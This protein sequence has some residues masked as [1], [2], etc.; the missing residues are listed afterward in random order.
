MPVWATQPSSRPWPKLVPEPPMARETPHSTGSSCPERLE[1]LAGNDW[2]NVSQNAACCKPHV[3]RAATVSGE[4]VSGETWALAGETTART[5]SDAAVKNTFMLVPS[6]RACAGITYARV[7]WRDAKGGPATCDC[8][9][10]WH[11]DLR[12]RD[13]SKLYSCRALLGEGQEDRRLLALDGESYKNGYGKFGRGG[14]RGGWMFASRAAWE[15]TYGPIPPNLCA[16]HHCDN[17]P[18]VRPDHLFLGTKAQNSA[19]M[20]AKGRST[21]GDRNPTRLYPEC[22]VR[23]ERQWLAKLSS[24]VVR[25]IRERYEAGGITQVALAAEYGVSFQT[26]HRVVR[27]KGWIHVTKSA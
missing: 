9:G 2:L 16:L 12:S 4:A 11:H 17:P 14:R 24:Q 8:P 19:D 1:G 23:G 27:Y 13:A 26:V 18:C 5:S 7:R 20:A 25:K 15:L 3:V 21:I 22:V 10:P 6:K